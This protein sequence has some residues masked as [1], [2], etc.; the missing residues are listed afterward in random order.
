MTLG[1]VMGWTAALLVAGGCGAAQAAWPDDQSID[2]VV[3]FAPGGGTDLM[4]RA[5]APYVEKRL[6]GRAHIVVVNKPGAG[7]EISSS[8]VSR[9]KPDGYTVG[10]IN[11]PGFM[12][13]PM[14]KKT[15]YL[16]SE[17]RIIARVVDDPALLVAR[18]DAR[19]GSLKS[20]V[21]ALRNDPG[22]LSFATSGRGTSGH[23][24]L[25]KIEKEA[26]VR[27]TDIAFKG[28][29]EFKSALLGGN[30]DYAFMSVAEFL[31][32]NDENSP[33]RPIVLFH[34]QPMPVLPGV[35]TAAQEGY[36]VLVLSLIHI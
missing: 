34:D 14:Y 20:I 18:K 32:S 2:L 24:A 15:A 16:P 36:T 30:V 21:E 3:G 17:M 31:V 4:A 22:S 25:M 5:M 33:L 35:P 1:R 13:I 19:H 9:A 29:G 8:Y 10:F 28:A 23:I 7:G 11:A 26:N 6:G 12:F 27:G